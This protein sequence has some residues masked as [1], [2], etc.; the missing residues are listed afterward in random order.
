MTNNPLTEKEIPFLLRR[1]R[2]GVHQGA[3]LEKYLFRLAAIANYWIFITDCEDDPLYADYKREREFFASC[4]KLRKKLPGFDEMSKPEGISTRTG[5]IIH[6]L[7]GEQGDFVKGLTELLAGN[8]DQAAPK[9]LDAINWGKHGI[10]VYFDELQGNAPEYLSCEYDEEKCIL[11]IYK[12]GYF[13]KRNLELGKYMEG[14]YTLS[15]ATVSSIEKSRRKK[16]LVAPEGEDFLVWRVF[17]S[18]FENES[19]PMVFRSKAD[20]VKE[21]EQFG[22][23]VQY[24][25]DEFTSMDKMKKLYLHDVE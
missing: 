3:T 2:I 18:P 4:I 21:V 6:G 9:F 23:D 25:F 10:W 12:G 13:F 7:S 5:R 16:P 1:T 17:T 8:Y 22:E 15:P 20:M 11:S 14:K 24:W 19:T